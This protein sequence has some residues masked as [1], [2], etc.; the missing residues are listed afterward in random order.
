MEFRQLRYFIAVAESGNIAA[1]SRRLHISQP[2]IT[3][4]IHALESELGVELLVR[5]HR[6]VDLTPAGSTFL[7]DAKRIVAL[8]DT[9]ATRSRSAARG[10]LGQLNVAYFGTPVLRVVPELLRAFLAKVPAASCSLIELSKDAQIQALADGKI[11]IGFGR[12]YPQHP[13]ITI[14]TVR[15][16]RL[17]IA[18]ADKVARGTKK[19]CTI[20]D[21]GHRKVIL[22]PQGGRPNWADAVVGLFRNVGVEPSVADIVEDVNAALALTYAGVG[23][24]VV[25]ET[26]ATMRWA[27]LHFTGIRGRH[28]TI[29]VSCIYAKEDRSPIVTTFI[30]VIR[31]MNW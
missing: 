30:D 8:S 20:T 10:E 15:E 7:E 26:V 14:A 3:R 23:I 2:P 11:H 18:S 13:N 24:T 17:F 31:G 6:G 28:S 9:S 25:P 19:N 29:P 12:F 4:Q 21:V 22:Y 27:G 5:S 1:A 16:E